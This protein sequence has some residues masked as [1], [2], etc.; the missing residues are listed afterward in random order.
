MDPQDLPLETAT[1]RGTCKVH[2]KGEHVRRF[3]KR[4]VEGESPAL[5]LHKA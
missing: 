3:L 2:K 4:Q 5:E 1:L